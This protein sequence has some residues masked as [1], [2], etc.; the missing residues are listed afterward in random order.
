MWQGHDGVPPKLTGIINQ[1]TNP[2][3]VQQLYG[4]EDVG[5]PNIG[6]ELNFQ[7]ILWFPPGT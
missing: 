1:M 2:L 6:N 7:L 5:K 3:D 4:C